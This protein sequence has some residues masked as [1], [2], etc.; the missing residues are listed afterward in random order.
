MNKNRD[1]TRS[2]WKETRSTKE[3]A[4]LNGTVLQQQIL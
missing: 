4:N 2:H 3:R 1:R